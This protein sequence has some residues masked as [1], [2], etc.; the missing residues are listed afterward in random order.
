[1]NGINVL[2]V[3]TSTLSK[4]I[5]GYMRFSTIFEMEQYFNERNAYDVL[6]KLRNKRLIRYYYETSNE[7]S[8]NSDIEYQSYYDKNKIELLYED[9]I[10]IDSDDIPNKSLYKFM[11]NIHEHDFIKNINLFVDNIKKLFPN[12]QTINYITIDAYTY[13]PKFYGVEKESIGVNKKF[14]KKYGIKFVHENHIRICFQDFIE[15]NNNKFDVVFFFGCCNPYYLI[16]I[17]EKYIYNFKKSLNINGYI[18][19]ADPIDSP[20]LN[21]ISLLNRMRYL[22]D[23]CGVKEYKINIVKFLC[24]YLIELD[25][26]IYKFKS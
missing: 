21:M 1:M 7:T 15:E 4:Y 17:N 22:I 23:E 13:P 25:D 5:P 26:G 14:S 2:L 3:G 12:V 6:A 9:G 10:E 24:N 18:L 8:S 11:E 19:H 20:G 16:D